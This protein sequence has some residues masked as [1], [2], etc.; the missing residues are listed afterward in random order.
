MAGNLTVAA[1]SRRR[2]GVTASAQAVLL[3]LVVAA[4][5]LLPAGIRYGR[6]RSLTRRLARTPMPVV[7]GPGPCSDS[8]PAPATIAPSGPRVTLVT[9]RLDVGGLENVV[10]M[11]AEGLGTQGLVTSVLCSGGGATF[12]ALAGAGID[13]SV[14]TTLDDATAQ[15]NRFRPDVVEIHNPPQHLMDAVLR[16]GAPWV[17]VIHN[18]EIHRG[19]DDWARIGRASAARWIAVSENAR[20]FHVAHVPPGSPADVV[21]VP[22]ASPTAPWARDDHTRREER[23]ALAEATGWALS[24]DLV[25]VVSL[26]RYDPQKN[27][28]GLVAC[29]AE[30]GRARPALRLVVAGPPADRLEVA[31]A[32]AIRR[33]SPDPDAVALLGSSSSASLLAAADAFVLDSYFEGGPIVAIEAARAGL[34]VVLSDV[35]IARELLRDG[36]RGTLVPNPATGETID[37]KSVRRARRHVR[38]QRNAGALRDALVDV[39]DHVAE[40]RDRRSSLA[41]SAAE[42]FTLEAMISGHTYWLKDAVR[43]DNRS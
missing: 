32:D 10:R 27:I 25:V 39:A 21:V 35:G 43:R 33:A 8:R 2:A 3:G 11:L 19:R 12:D 20:D 15:L 5:D 4:T 23:R 31:W 41:E 29:F 30:A 28:A 38:S 24:E 1:P 6:L 22:N 17:G 34:P 9:G 40:W 16:Y 13:L 7:T 26:A 42:L 18:P 36:T 37:E 14:A